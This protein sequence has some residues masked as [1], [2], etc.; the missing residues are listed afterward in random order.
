MPEIDNVRASTQGG[1]VDLDT[2]LLRAL[3]VTA[4]ELHFGRAA[5][6]LVITQQALSKRIAR[7]ESLVGVQLLERDNRHVELTS[8]G[9]RLLPYAREAIEAIDAAAVVAGVGGPIRVDVMENHTAAVALVREAR[10]R[11]PGLTIETSA[12]G[13]A[14]SAPDVLRSGDADIALG[15]ADAAS[16]PTNLRRRR[17]F[18]EPLGLLVGAGHALA[19]R[20]HVT[21]GELAGTR[22]EFPM[23][24]A[25]TDW[26]RFID[27][28]AAT[29]SLSVDTTGCSLGFDHFVDHPAEH[30]Q[31]ASFFGLGM[32]APV[33][34]RLRVVPIVEPT[35]LFPWAVMWRRRYPEAVVD[36]V[37]PLVGA[38]APSDAWLPVADQAWI[39]R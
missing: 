5:D 10:D 26:V 16:W 20:D 38:D 32:R 8:A 31:S 6:R 35:P 19:S 9:S 4:E 1:G 24:G 27:E 23:M 25:P 36:A 33:D 34:P 18:L 30:D 37:V 21:M 3:V 12:R 17:A 15:R 29:F 2:A 14:R 13:A 28:L 11:N 39:L 22:L 7:L